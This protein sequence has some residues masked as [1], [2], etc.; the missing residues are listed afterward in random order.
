MEII[1]LFHLKKIRLN[2]AS[3]GRILCIENDEKLTQEEVDRADEL[4][5]I[6]FPDEWKDQNPNDKKED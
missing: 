6:A 5:Q 4:Q 3:S 1:I 2:K